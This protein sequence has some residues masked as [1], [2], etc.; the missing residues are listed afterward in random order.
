MPKKKGNIMKNKKIL[1]ILICVLIIIIISLFFIIKKFN[2]QETTEENPTLTEYTPEEE[3]SSE[4]LRETIVTLYFVDADNNLKSEGKLIDSV[5]LLKNPYKELIS[6]LI[7]GPTSDTLRNVFP[8]GTNI[9]DATIINNCVTLNFSEQ[10]LNYT[11]DNQKYNII[12]SI[13]NTLTELNEVNSIK[14]LVNNAPA[15]KFNEEYT[16]KT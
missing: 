7:S 13:L 2:S 10:I 12:N 15:E 4:Q 8:E 5:K 3:I 6:L 1:F 14:I 11:D 16:I 9:L